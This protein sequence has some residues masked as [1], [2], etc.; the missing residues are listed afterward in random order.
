MT[1]SFGGKQDA[2]YF[3][4]TDGEFDG[5]A[6]GQF[7]DAVA[8]EGMELFLRATGNFPKVRAIPLM[9]AEE[10]KQAMEKAKNAKSSYTPPTATK[11]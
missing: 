2:I 5:M 8:V 7:P 9:N 3:F 11:Q 6:I 4:P 10:F 1:E